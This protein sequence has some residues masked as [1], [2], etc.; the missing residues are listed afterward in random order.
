[1]DTF[2]RIVACG[3]LVLVVASCS[4]TSS[5][6]SESNDAAG[7]QS[8]PGPDQ[9]SQSPSGAGSPAPNSKST[10]PSNTD[11]QMGTSGPDTSSAPSQRVPESISTETTSGAGP[12]PV[13][14]TATTTVTVTATTTAGKPT[15]GAGKSKTHTKMCNDLIGVNSTTSC[16]FAQNVANAIA[17]KPPTKKSFSV[18]AWS[19]STN[20]SYVVK[21]RAQTKFMYCTGGSNARIWVYYN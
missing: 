14:R 12:T 10:Q 4:G 2:W 11:D 18:R 1:M 13:T 16:A 17:A 20:K 3:V 19:P 9:G 7:T 15:K 8:T 6:S 5:V 21:C